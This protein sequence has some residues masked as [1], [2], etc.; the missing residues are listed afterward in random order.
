VVDPYEG[1]IIQPGLKG[2]AEHNIYSGT[3]D[4]FKNSYE[5]IGPSLKERVGK[6]KD[7]KNMDQYL[8]SIDHALKAA[9]T[10]ELTKRNIESGVPLQ[11][12]K[13]FIKKNPD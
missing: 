2:V 7:G 3:L 4:S 6:T 9:R 10:I 13:N 8:N 5:I 1:L 12:S 11:A